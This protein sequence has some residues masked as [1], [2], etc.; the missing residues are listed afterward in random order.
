M[1]AHLPHLGYLY[2][3]R[4][5]ALQDLEKIEEFPT[6][7]TVRILCAT[8]SSQVLTISQGRKMFGIT[9]ENIFTILYFQIL[10]KQCFS[11]STFE[12]SVQEIVT[13]NSECHIYILLQVPTH[14]K[15][16]QN[17]IC[18]NSNVLIIVLYVFPPCEYSVGHE[19]KPLNLSLRCTDK[20]WY[21]RAVLV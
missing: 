21:F 10:I 11:F 4:S 2:I 19:Y 8:S 12:N 15:F 5:I 13:Y 16:L 18:K 6:P 17:P 7:M 3:L 20:M 1:Y 14:Y 9:F